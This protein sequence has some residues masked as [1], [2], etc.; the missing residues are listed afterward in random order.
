MSV[1]V[2]DSVWS[3][4]GDSGLLSDWSRDESRECCERSEA[5]EVE[6]ESR[7]CWE[8]SPPEHRASSESEHR[9]QGI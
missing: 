7:G 2:V 6:E 9:G 3:R 5:S 4:G 1:V 8:R